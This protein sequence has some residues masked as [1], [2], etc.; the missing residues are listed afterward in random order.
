MHNNQLTYCVD[1]YR[2]EIYSNNAKEEGD[3]EEVLS[4]LSAPAAQMF[5]A[6]QAAL[7]LL[8]KATLSGNFDCIVC[9]IFAF[10]SSDR[11]SCC[12]AAPSHT[13]QTF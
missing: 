3:R 2:H 7:Y 5:S 1:S 9:L 11:S 10:V 12:D 13:K 8:A 6:A 4:F